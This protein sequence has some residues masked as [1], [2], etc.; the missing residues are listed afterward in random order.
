[1]IPNIKTVVYFA[2]EFST[3]KRVSYFYEQFFLLQ[4]DTY[5][6]NLPPCPTVTEFLLKLLQFSTL[7]RCSRLVSYSEKKPVLKFESLLQAR[8]HP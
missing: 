7:T 1:M 5:M 8:F 3:W 2:P 4:I 6:G